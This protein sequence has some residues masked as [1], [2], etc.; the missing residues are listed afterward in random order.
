MP[1]AFH[2]EVHTFSNIQVRVYAA[3]QILLDEGLSPLLELFLLFFSQPQCHLLH[4]FPDEFRL[5]EGLV[6][7]IFAAEGACGFVLQ[8]FLEAGEAEGVSAVCD[9]WVDHEI[10]ADRTI[11]LFWLSDG[12]V[13]LTAEINFPLALS[14]PLLALH[15]RS[16]SLPQFLSAHLRPC[17]K[18]PTLFRNGLQF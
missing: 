13:V 14:F 17:H 2:V 9:N 11:E 4:D 16:H 5:A 3:F 6:I 10:Q 12:D 15:P 18:G 7:E 8:G 1:H